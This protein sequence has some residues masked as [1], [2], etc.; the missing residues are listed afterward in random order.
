MLQKDG[1]FLWR[2]FSLYY[3]SC[4]I[5]HYLIVQWEILVVYSKYICMCPTT[6]HKYIY[7]HVAWQ[8]VGPKASFLTEA[9]H[10][11]L[12]VAPSIKV[13]RPL[14]LV[15]SNCFKFDQVCRK[16]YQHVQCPI[17]TLRRPISWLIWWRRCYFFSTNLVK[18]ETVWRNA[19][20]SGLLCIDR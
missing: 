1:R 12:S 15:K 5:W 9:K 6:N 4:S 8:Q 2:N 16:K 17:N 10:R 7:M 19:I 20:L 3:N 11:P 14:S 18:L 13:L